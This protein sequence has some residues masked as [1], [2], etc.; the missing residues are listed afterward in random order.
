MHCRGEG[1]IGEDV[2]GA[3]YEIVQ[4]RE[5]HELLNLRDAIVRAPAQ[6]NGAHWSQAADRFGQALLDGFNA[7]N[8]RR[9]HGAQ[10]DQQNAKFSFSGRDFRA[11]L[12]RHSSSLSSKTIKT[13][14]KRPMMIHETCMIRTRSALRSRT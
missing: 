12:Y 3:K 7:G 11:F 8:E 5:R 4:I 14:N 9:A 2:P 6:T 1:R 13:G 10:S